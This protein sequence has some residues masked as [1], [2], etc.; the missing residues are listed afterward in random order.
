MQETAAQSAAAFE[1][2]AIEFYNRHAVKGGAYNL[3]QAERYERFAQA[4]SERAKVE[5]QAAPV[6][7]VAAV[8]AKPAKAR[9]PHY[10]NIQTFMAIAREAGLN[11][12]A[13][14]RCRGAVGALLGRRIESRADLTG[15]EWAAMGAAIKAGKLVW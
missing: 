10:K 14:D 8:E 11:T 12:S 15:A 3:S 2:K 13:K 4:A 9:C 6:V 5:A 7:E 1:R